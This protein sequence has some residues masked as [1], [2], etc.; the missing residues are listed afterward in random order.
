MS[1]M[2]KL[3]SAASMAKWKADQQ[4]RIVR[5]Q[6][7]IHDLENQVKAQKNSL[8][9][10]VLGLYAQGNLS[11]ESLKTVCAAIGQ[12]NSQIASVTESLHQIQAEQAPSENQPAPAAAAPAPVA[13]PSAAPSAA[14]VMINVA[15]A[16]AAAVVM[17]CPQCGQV[18]KGKFCP[19]HGVEGVPAPNQG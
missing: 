5:T 16:P 2:N 7:N 14:P 9:E 1:F 3:G 18:L 8:A 19:E 4:M 12:L 15:P 17:V 10:A 13:A 11:E 6:N